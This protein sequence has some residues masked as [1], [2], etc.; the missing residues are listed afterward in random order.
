MNAHDT[1]LHFEIPRPPLPQSR[2]EEA[3]N[4]R[5]TYTEIRLEGQQPHNEGD[6]GR[7]IIPETQG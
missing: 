3:Q 5:C 7:I 1:H 4:K 2:L 6:G